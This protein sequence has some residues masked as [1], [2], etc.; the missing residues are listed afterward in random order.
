MVFSGD[1]KET[2]NRK[3]GCWVR[4]NARTDKVCCFATQNSVIS[5]LLGINLNL[6]VPG[7]QIGDFYRTRVFAMS[8]MTIFIAQG[9]VTYFSKQLIIQQ[10]K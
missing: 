1:K 8:R 3:I 4:R 5:L 7:G 2:A 6:L 9:S 10:T